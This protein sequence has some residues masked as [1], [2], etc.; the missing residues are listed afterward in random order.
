MPPLIGQHRPSHEDQIHFHHQQA[1]GSCDIAFKKKSISTSLPPS[2]P[3]TTS[4]KSA[5]PFPNSLSF[6]DKVKIGSKSTTMSTATSP[7]CSLNITFLVFRSSVDRESSP[8][9]SIRKFAI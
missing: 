2:E 4:P 3:T 1:T 6:D 7:L 8:P 5:T 9:S